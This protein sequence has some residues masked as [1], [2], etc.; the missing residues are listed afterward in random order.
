MAKGKIG[1]TTENIFPIIKKYIS[2]PIMRS[3]YENWFQMQWMPHR[4]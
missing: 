4:N 2:T 3:S 1:V